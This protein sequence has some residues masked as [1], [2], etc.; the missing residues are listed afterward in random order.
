MTLMS[1]PTSAQEHPLGSRGLRRP[2]FD[3]KRILVSA[4]SMEGERLAPI[5]LAPLSP[6]FLDSCRQL[7]WLWDLDAV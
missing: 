1:P 4:V 3:D 5:Q 6:C 7:S 2:G